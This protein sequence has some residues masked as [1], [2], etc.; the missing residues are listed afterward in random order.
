V[1]RQ[2]REL[3]ATTN[4]DHIAVRSGGP[5]EATSPNRWTAFE[6]HAVPKNPTKG[7]ESHPARCEV[8]GNDYDNTFQ[9]VTATGTHTFDSF[10]C[11]IHRLAPTCGCCGCRVVGHGVE[12]G[13]V[14]YCCANCA[15]IAGVVGARDHV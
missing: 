15:L 10:E 8:C 2:V 1:L 13:E 14:V 11:A 3:A 4:S 5:L 9:V 7:G 6:A 12:A